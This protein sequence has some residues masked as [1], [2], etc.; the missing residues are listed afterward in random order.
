MK[1]AL[2]MHYNVMLQSLTYCFSSNLAYKSFIFPIASSPLKT[3]ELNTF[4]GDR[5]DS[6]QINS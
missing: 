4:K 5:A 3:Q 6:N 2:E 1:E